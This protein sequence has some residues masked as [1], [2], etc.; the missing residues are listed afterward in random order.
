M[1]ATFKNVQYELA[2]RNGETLRE[3]FDVSRL[4]G[5]LRGSDPSDVTST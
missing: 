4:F 1:T 5:E 3:S 2:R